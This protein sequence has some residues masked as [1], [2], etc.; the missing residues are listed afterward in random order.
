[1]L[2]GRHRP[3]TVWWCLTTVLVHCA[4]QQYSQLGTAAG[5]GAGCCCLWEE[6]AVAL[7]VSSLL[8]VLTDVLSDI[9]DESA[10]PALHCTVTT[11]HS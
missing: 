3:V 11:P 2:C 6:E 7:T 5:S 4:P 8:L 1:M 10:C 9:I